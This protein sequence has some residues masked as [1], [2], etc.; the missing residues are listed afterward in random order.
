MS[1]QASA[2]RSAIAGCYHV[3][4]DLPVK[5][6]RT[7]MKYGIANGYARLSYRIRIEVRSGAKLGIVLI[8]GAAIELTHQALT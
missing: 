2:C 7:V 1:G 8:Q 5:L 6:K 4:A 3:N